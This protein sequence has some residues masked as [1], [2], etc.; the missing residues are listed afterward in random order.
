M[1]LNLLLL[2]DSD[3]DALL[4][5]LFLKRGLPGCE[6]TVVNTLDDVES[7]LRRGFFDAMISDFQL[8]TFTGMDAFE[9][10]QS[11]GSDLPFILVSGTMGDELA[12][13]ALKAGV[14]D[15]VAKSNL[16]R[17]PSAIEREVAAAQVR[18]QKKAADHVL[19]TN[20]HNLQALIENTDDCI[21]SINR[22]MQITILNH[23]AKSCFKAMY[24]VD[25]HAGMYFPDGLPAS[26]ITAWDR[27][28]KSAF[29]GQKSH[30]ELP[31]TFEEGSERIMDV[32]VNPILDAES[33][34]SGVS[35]FAKD[36]TQRKLWEEQ[37][38]ANLKEKE[39]LL[40]EI[41]HRV[42]NNLAIVSSILMLQ[43]DKIEDELYK[44]VYTEAINKIKSIALIHEKLYQNKSLAEIEFS[45]YIRSL[46]ESVASSM[47]VGKQVR[48]DVDAEPMIL[49]IIQAIPC[50]LILSELLTNAFKHAF[51]DQD[52]GRI[53]IEFRKKEAGFL[54]RVIDDGNR[55][56]V[57]QRVENSAS[58]GMMIVRGLAE[59]LNASLHFESDNGTVVTLEK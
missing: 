2:E 10:L 43:Q 24:G 45:E 57:L 52:T 47:H 41:H 22:N 13:Q 26:V 4:L 15:F 42:K 46:A 39:I 44:Q 21:W 19:Q 5:N 55:P 49:D 30:H 34:I 12:V 40:A 27:I 20:Q 11:T 28:V 36:I 31:F 29:L 54:L 8:G 35:F 25:L 37:L 53:L 14:S 23:A 9:R 6:I 16:S 59:Q 56:D 7:N 48:V 58:V 17:L 18:R 32:S 1:P 33:V 51:R 3:N 38:G 50:G